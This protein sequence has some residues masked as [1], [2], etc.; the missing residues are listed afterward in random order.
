MRAVVYRA[1]RRC[2]Q[3]GAAPLLIILALVSAIAPAPVEAQGLGFVQ[4]NS[5]PPLTSAGSVTAGVTAAQNAGDTN[6]VAVGWNDT[7][8]AVQ[9]VTDTRGNTYIRAVGPTASPG[10]ATQ[11]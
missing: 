2:A 4:S 8:T 11:S 3:A 5:S 9:S 10:V 7:K 1:M 6:V